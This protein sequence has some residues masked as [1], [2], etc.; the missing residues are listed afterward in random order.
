MKRILLTFLIALPF[1]LF[2]QDLYFPPVLGN[3]WDTTSLSELGWCDDKLDD[4]I[5][6]LEDGGTKAF[7]VLKDGKMVIEKYFG[8]FE[9]DDTHQWNS[10]GKTMTSFLVGIA[11]QE[12]H[13]DISDATSDYL[14]NGWTSLPA[15]KED[16]ITI[17]H[18]LTMTSGM[19]D[20]G[21]SNCT[22]PACLTYVAD[23][24]TRWA[25][26]N[27]PYTLLDSVIESATGKNL[28]NY[29]SSKML[30]QTGIGG[31]FIPLGDNKVFFS[32]PRN[33]ARFGLLILNRGKWKNTEILSDQTYFDEMTTRSQDINNG[34][35]YLWWLN[36]T[37]DYK[38]PASQLTFQ[39]NPTS[40]APKDM[41]SG[42]GKN[43]QFVD[44]VPSE[45]LVVIRMGD[46]PNSNGPMPAD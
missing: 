21:N 38:L 2:A 13:L 37:D 19:D 3:V 29:L 41:Y 25:Y 34:Y 23:A 11:Q 46:S 30:L 20:S 16:L 17:R 24:G 15:E 40:A 1:H 10:A 31:L 9:Q 22:D 14:G 26:H 32:K 28:N 36:D 12:G 42:I 6:H 7:I 45:K 33:M 18:Q 5:T 39:G 44:I 4:L 8:D 27:A 35:G 43:G